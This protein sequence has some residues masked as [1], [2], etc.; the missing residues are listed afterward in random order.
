MPSP[1]IDPMSDLWGIGDDG[2]G[3]VQ[4]AT[5]V[6]P[7]G[8]GIPEHLLAGLNPPQRDAVEYRGPAL[9]IVAGAGSGA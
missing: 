1:R 9:L 8:D 2:F 7:R 5:P 6:G 4:R 3:D